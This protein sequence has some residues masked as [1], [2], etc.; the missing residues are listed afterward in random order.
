MPKDNIDRFIHISRLYFKIYLGVSSCI[1]LFILFFQPFPP[2]NFD[3]EN[4]LLYNSGYGL[5]IFLAQVILQIVFRPYLVPEKT[6]KP[7]AS[8]FHSVYYLSLVLFPGICFVFYLRYVGNTDIT[9]NIALRTIIICLA[10]PVTIHLKMKLT[11]LQTG[12]DKLA[13]ENRSMKNKI[14]QSPLHYTNKVI[15]LNSENKLD[16]LRI[17]LAEI[18]FIRSADNYV[19]ICFSENGIVQKKMVRNTLKN[20]EVQLLDFNQFVRSHRSSIVNTQYIN[21][22]NK[23]FNTY[24]LTLEG[25]QETIAVS[26]QY[27]LA[28]KAAC[29]GIGTNGIHQ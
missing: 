9:F 18:I 10:T 24:S 8:V 5:I 2:T 27:L 22:L 12:N 3:F 13:E 23:H 16:N 29:E 6:D 15:E 19:E 14:T 21:K 20:I 17:K 1:F 26:R 7:Y 28:V 25:T 4:K 11:S